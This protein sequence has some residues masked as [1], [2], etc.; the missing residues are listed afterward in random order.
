M[1]GGEGEVASFCP[2]C[3]EQLVVGL[4]GNDADHPGYLVHYAVPAAHWWD[5]IGFS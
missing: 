4:S 1:L 2:D 3:A 5:E